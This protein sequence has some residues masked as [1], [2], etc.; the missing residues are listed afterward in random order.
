MFLGKIE[1]PSPLSAEWPTP[2]DLASLLKEAGGAWDSLGHVPPSTEGYLLPPGYPQDGET[3]EEAIA[4][5]AKAWRH[6][7]LP[8]AFSEAAKEGG[9]KSFAITAEED[10]KQFLDTGLSGCPP[11]PLFM[12]TLLLPPH[13]VFKLHSHPTFELIVCLRGKLGEVRLIGQMGRPFSVPT[14]GPFTRVDGE[15]VGPDLSQIPAV[16]CMCTCV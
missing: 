12:Q 5:L 13:K 9:K 14:R 7:I 2:E 1:V 3:V 8:S 15:L 11:Q 16:V 6:E 4:R 10:L